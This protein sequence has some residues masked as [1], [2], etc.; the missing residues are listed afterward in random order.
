MFW[1]TASSVPGEASPSFRWS[2]EATVEGVQALRQQKVAM[3]AALGAVTAALRCN[4]HVDMKIALKEA[5]DSL[6]PTWQ[7][8]LWLAS[9]TGS[10]GGLGGLV[11]SRR[12]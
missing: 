11:L 5:A 1:A 7:D 4:F 10:L 9:L 2:S 12:R 8:A 3:Q 6:E